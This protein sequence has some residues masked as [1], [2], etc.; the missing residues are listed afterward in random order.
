[1]GEW[2]K[3]KK[4]KKK[5][6]ELNQDVAFNPSEAPGRSKEP[7]SALNVVSVLGNIIILN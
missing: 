7:A 6:R 5:K 2:Q 3:K 1:L 4:K